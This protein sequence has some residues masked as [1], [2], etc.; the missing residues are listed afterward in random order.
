MTQPI[1][2]PPIELAE[3]IKRGDTEI[4]EITLRRPGA[5]ELRGLRLGDL[6][7]G[8]VNSVIRLLP[9]ISQPTLI[10][11]EAAA[12]DAFDITSCADQIAVFLQTPPQKTAASDSPEK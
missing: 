4:K 12:M 2:S 3:P 9:R 10:E 5:G 11:Q 1:Y 6:V 7:Q 8:D